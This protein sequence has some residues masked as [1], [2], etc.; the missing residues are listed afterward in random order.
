M[1]DMERLSILSIRGWLG[2]WAAGAM[3]LAQL[4]V[5]MDPGLAFA[6][7]EDDEAKRDF[8]R[9][10]VSS[11]YAATLDRLIRAPFADL[12]ALSPG[13]EDESRLRV[14]CFR[15][16]QSESAVGAAQRMVLPVSIGRVRE[17]LGRFDE[18]ERIFRGYKHIRMIER[19]GPRWLSY[20][21]Q[22]IPIPL[23][24]NVKYRML[25]EVGP[26]GA[27]PLFYRYRM[28]WSNTLKYSDG[29]IRIEA[30]PKNKE[31]TR[32]LELD[33]WDANLGI[34]GVI[35]PAKVVQESVEG[36]Y[37]S[38]LAIRLR[39]ENPDWPAE[40][41][42]SESVK[43]IPDSDVERCVRERTDFKAPVAVS[44]F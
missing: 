43:R 8:D 5:A 37:Q 23:V 44:G 42:L 4:S 6:Q 25:Y 18:Y 13:G 36:I 34:A 15:S 16:P 40:R 12:W 38:D 19:R 29:L 11:A 35:A 7:D 9:P 10:A 1:G 22:R 28:S 3:F 31:R 41:V 21:E 26:D 32:Y 33:F 24:S 39:A 17:V 27:S 30:D 2:P 20:W 14:V